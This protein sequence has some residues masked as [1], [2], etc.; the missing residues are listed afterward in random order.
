MSQRNSNN[1]ASPGV[2][3]VARGLAVLRAFRS[4]RTPLTNV[5]LVRR[6][7]LAKAT[8]SRLTSTLVQAGFIRRVLG[9][10]NFVLSTG[11]LGIG[12]SY[13]STSSLLNAARP[14]MQ[15]LADR[16]DA[17]VALAV[18]D[19]IDML[20]VSH[21]SSR[22]IATLKLRAGL[23]LPMGTTAIGRAYLWGLPPQEK[24][25]LLLTFQKSA[26]ENG[27]QLIHDIHESFTE[28]DAT[29]T[30]F[31]SGGYIK[32]SYGVALSLQLGANLARF[33]MSCGKTLLPESLEEERRTIA[34]ELK[35]AASELKKLLSNLDAKI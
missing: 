25:Q 34:T 7:G 28:L 26:K 11:A 3:T 18:Q 32:N 14:L 2:M 23:I 5:E 10:R 31:V 30:C 29:G 24:K 12:L 35:R 22:K 13:L 4:D 33:A 15:S 6:T 8:V 19:G 27:E 9:K 17:S 20:Y 16:L 1:V 21:C